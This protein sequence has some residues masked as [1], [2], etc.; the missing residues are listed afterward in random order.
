ML[1]N[2]RTW[3]I[4][5]LQG[6][7]VFSSLVMAWTLRF[8]FSC[9]QPALLLAAAPVLLILRLASMARF[10]L[11]HGYW[12][13]SGLRDAED[14]LK[15][16]GLGTAG[17]VFAIRY[18]LG[19]TRFPLSIYVLEALL[20]ALLLG[21]V[22]FF[23]RALLQRS[24][25][26][27]RRRR[28]DDPPGR[29]LIVG[30]GAGAEMLIRE[31]PQHGYTP[32]G[33]V[34]DDPAKRKVKIHGVPVLGRIEELPGIAS[35]HQIDELMIALPSVSGVRMRRIIEICQNSHRKF[36][37]IPGVRDLL[38]GRVT[39]GQLREVQLEDLLGREPVQLDLA[40]VRRDVE[41]KV[42]MVTGAAGSIGSELCH[43]ILGYGPAKLICLDQ[44]ETPLFY[45][46]SALAKNPSGARATHCVAD[47]NDAAYIRRLLRQYGVQM[48][49]HAA[50]YK[51]VPMMET[52]LHEALK[53]NVF[54]LLS[55]LDVAQQS[56]CEGFVLISSD[57]AVHPSSFMGCTKRLGEL[58]VAARPAS[59]MRCLS[60]RFG[61][62]LGSQGSVV[63]IFQEQI[64]TTQRITVTHPHITRYF[65]TIP[66]AVS[67]V[68]EAYTVG[69]H[70]DVLVLD[71]GEPVRILELAKTLIRLS[72]KSEKEIEITFTGLRAG[73]KLYEELFYSSEEQLPTPSPKIKRAQSKRMSWQGL[74]EH[75]AVLAAL[76]ANGSQTSIRKKMK[77]I[78]PEYQYEPEFHAPQE[79]RMP[80]LTTPI[81]PPPGDGIPGLVASA[82]STNLRQT[83]GTFPGSE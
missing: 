60:V 47:I 26:I 64:R 2:Q 42:V 69:K 43:Q 7:L 74:R 29:V 65:M 23:S 50:A 73:E 4:V 10:G 81:P 55:L 30:A 78:I 80:L 83:P 41:G 76:T 9:P 1:L 77:E 3:A 14:V 31:L 44:A 25:R 82:P 72:G 21:G 8:E 13:Y 68:L 57:K 19:M 40:S 75:L 48:I 17:F 32:V 5:L 15:S 39:V 49:F 11:F 67:L 27:D 79:P 38:E 35:N 22:R 20:T 6:L 66:E 53:N 56:E 51:H 71:M 16:V 18:V 54:A 52:N 61:N 34:D 62:V 24:R 37:I 12:R 28:H 58:M 59:I 70:G 45:L 33:C 63:P 36:K 46:E